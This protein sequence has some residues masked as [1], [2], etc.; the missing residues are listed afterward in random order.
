MICC[1][2]HDC[3]NTWYNE[4]FHDIKAFEDV[5]V[6]A[7][8]QLSNIIIIIIW[9]IYIRFLHF[10]RLS[11]GDL[12]KPFSFGTDNFSIP[13]SNHLFVILKLRNNEIRYFLIWYFMYKIMLF[14]R[15]RFDVYQ[16]SPPSWSLVCGIGY[17]L[18]DLQIHTF[19]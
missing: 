5:N 16:F 9:N 13:V 10:L 14:F 11:F 1:S 6:A 2:W 8:K 3:N 15:N 4:I 12:S 19:Q 18:L 17:L 7:I